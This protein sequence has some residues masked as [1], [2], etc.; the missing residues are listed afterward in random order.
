V[1]EILAL[2]TLTD[3]TRNTLVSKMDNPMSLTDGKLCLIV[4][5]N[6]IDDVDGN[7]AHFELA[8]HKVCWDGEVIWSIEYQLISTSLTEQKP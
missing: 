7:T 6:S 4:L 2:G 8:S 1:L 3:T 5:E